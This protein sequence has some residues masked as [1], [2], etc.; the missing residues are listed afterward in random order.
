MAHPS[1]THVLIDFSV[2]A[3]Q[4][5]NALK[6]LAS[7]GRTKKIHNSVASSQYDSLLNFLHNTWTERP[8]FSSH[9]VEEPAQRNSQDVVGITQNLHC[10]DETLHLLVGP[11]LCRCFAA[12]RGR[13]CSG[14]AG[15]LAAHQRSGRG[16]GN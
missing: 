6:V 14:C 7:G 4:L 2:R 5:G 8:S 13:G 3:G 1:A 9:F 16:H 12:R 11:Q 10:A 15:R